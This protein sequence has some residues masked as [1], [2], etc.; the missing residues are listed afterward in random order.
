MS[1]VMSNK[2]KAVG[3]LAS[4]IQLKMYMSIDTDFNTALDLAL[5]AA[6]DN[7]CSLLVNI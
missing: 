1:V 2:E 4:C 5:P 6:Y 3:F 7:L